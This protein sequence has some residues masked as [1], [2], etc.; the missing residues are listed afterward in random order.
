MGR[1]TDDPELRYTTT[2]TAVAT[3]TLAVPRDYKTKDGQEITDFLTCVAWRQTAE[4][5]S[6]HFKKGSTALV[7]GSLET[8][9][10][11]DKDG[12]KRTAY[13]IKVERVYFA[14]SKKSD[15]GQQAAPAQDFEEIDINEEDL[16]F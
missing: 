3:F 12:N 6:K 1:F 7:S 9:G 11:K 13:E 2:R 5:I 16:P 10:Y 4:F 15:N 8:R 14:G